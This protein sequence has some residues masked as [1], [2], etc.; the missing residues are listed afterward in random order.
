[1]DQFMPPKKIL[2]A[3]PPRMMVEINNAVY[4]EHCTRSEWLRAAVREHLIKHKR[5]YG[6]TNA[7]G[8]ERQADLAEAWA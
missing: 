2:L 8:P 7:G 5:V 4:A 1:M 6:N 3:V